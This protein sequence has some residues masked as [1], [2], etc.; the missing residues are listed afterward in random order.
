[1]D[2]T[3]SIIN[4]VKGCIQQSIEINPE[5]TFE[6]FI[7]IFNNV[8]IQ[9]DEND[10]LKK[11]INI[12]PFKFLRKHSPNFEHF[13]GTTFNSLNKKIKIGI[14]ISGGVN[15]DIYK[16]IIEYDNGDTHDIVIRTARMLSRSLKYLRTKE[17]IESLL[18]R[19]IKEN[20]IGI[21]LYCYCEYYVKNGYFSLGNPFLQIKGVYKFNNQTA[22]TF[23]KDSIHPANVSIVSV[24]EKIEYSLLE[25][26]R[27]DTTFDNDLFGILAWISF[28]LYKLQDKIDFSHRDFH[29]GNVMVKKIESSTINVGYLITKQEFRPYIIDFDEICI[30]LRCDNCIN[31]QAPEYK[32]DPYKLCNNRSHDLRR[33]LRSFIGYTKHDSIFFK[34]IGYKLGLLIEYDE[35]YFY[36]EI[37]KYEDPAFL[38]QIILNEI[39]LFF[40]ESGSYKEFD[41]DSNLAQILQG[42]LYDVK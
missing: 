18:L 26:V 3:Q 37:I 5:N 34:Y 7:D 36:D 28:N 17:R 8:L 38:P 20:L 15:S 6:D 42:K 14:K 13:N 32:E 31:L 1:M 22:A 11:L 41:I 12:L 19:D 23:D 25:I 40:D 9:Q 27:K 39:R 29:I 33:L 35:M 2:S 30:N 4:S 10:N 21:I 24:I 16:G